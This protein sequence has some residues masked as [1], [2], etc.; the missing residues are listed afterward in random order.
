MWVEDVDGD[1]IPE[2]LVQFHCG[3]HGQG[4]QIYTVNKGRGRLQLMEGGEIWSNWSEITTNKEGDRYTIPAKQRDYSSN[5]ETMGPII[6]KYEI[7]DSEVMRI[8]C[9]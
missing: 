8:T 4:L 1:N 3:A 2:L 7:V 6:E 5:R 9:S